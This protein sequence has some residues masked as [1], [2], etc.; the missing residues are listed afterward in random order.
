[1]DYPARY[2]LHRRTHAALQWGFLLALLADLAGLV[3]T[4]PALLV[5][6]VLAVVDVAATLYAATAVPPK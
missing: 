5:V 4:S 2:R 1:M 6:A 3:G